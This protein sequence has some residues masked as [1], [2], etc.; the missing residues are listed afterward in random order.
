MSL[1]HE[2]KCS[3]FEPKQS[4]FF[5]FTFTLAGHTSN[6]K[7]QLYFPSFFSNF[8]F[9][10][11]FEIRQTHMEEVFLFEI[12]ISQSQVEIC[13]LFSFVVGYCCSISRKREHYN[14]WLSWKKNKTK[15]SNCNYCIVFVLFIAKRVIYFLL[16]LLLFFVS[17]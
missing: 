3:M 8:I 16:L 9:V 13:Y 2:N 6:H 5:F 12:L 14:N 1:I 7:E 15:A 4:N 11:I 10:S 17:N